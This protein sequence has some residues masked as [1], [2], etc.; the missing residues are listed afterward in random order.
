MRFIL[1]VLMFWCCTALT[2]SSTRTNGQTAIRMASQDVYLAGNTIRIGDVATITCDSTAQAQAISKIDIEVFPDAEDKAVVTRQQLRIRAMLAGHEV[3]A[4]RMTGPESVIIRRVNRQD[5]RHSIESA[6]RN[7]VVSQFGI[8]EDDL[9]VTL[10]PQFKNPLGTTS[11]SSLK[12]APWGR[13]DLPLGRQSLTVTAIVANELT[14][15]NASLTIAVMRELAIAEREISSGDKLTAENVVAVRRPVS[16][17]SN[18]YMTLDQA[19]GKTA[20]A[21]IEKYGLIQPNRV[22]IERATEVVI[23]RNSLINV[24]VKRGPLMV[25]LRDVKAIN[26]GKQGERVQLVNPHT[27]ERM[28][29]K[30]VDSNTAHLF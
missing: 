27:G 26:D 22:R 2:F 19:L 25:T 14:T 18:S 17:R 6:V 24:I 5:I 23:K 21:N 10:D 9:Q 13:P 28:S 8:A 1:F 7:Q 11:F 3:T 15:F 4:A 20:K 16:T 29:A 30:V 12:V